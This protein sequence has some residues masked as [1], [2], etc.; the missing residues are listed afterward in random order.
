MFTNVWN[1][2][3]YGTNKTDLR[4]I[5]ENGNLD[6]KIAKKW[7]KPKFYHFFWKNLKKRRK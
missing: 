7:L 3:I 1:T 6:K 4:N 2:Q 5:S